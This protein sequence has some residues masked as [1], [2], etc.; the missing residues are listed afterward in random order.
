MSLFK[1]KELWSFTNS[2]NENYTSR[3]LAF[4]PSEN[5]LASKFRTSLI[6][7]ASV[8]G[9]LRLYHPILQAS[10]SDGLLLELDLKLPIL[11]I[12]VGNFSR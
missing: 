6:F 7:T 4:F 11:Q 8:E 5:V 2:T 10:N 1:T 3:S 9:Q 12:D